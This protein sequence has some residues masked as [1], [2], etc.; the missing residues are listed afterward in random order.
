MEVYLP[1]VTGP[2]GITAQTE[3]S[4]VNETD[5]TF[6][7]L[8]AALSTYAGQVTVSQQ[9]LDRT[10]PGFSFDRMIFDQ[11]NRDYCPKVD[12]KALNTVLG[13]ATSQSWT[14]NAGAFD[15]VAASGAGGFYGQVS[16]AKA[17][18]RT[19]AGTVLN[20]T[21]LFLVPQRWEFIAAWSDSQGRPVVVPDYAGVMN[22]AA[23][24][25]AD[26]D[27]GIEGRT[28][29]RLNGLPVFTDANIPNLGTTSTDQAIVGD[30]GEC[31][32]FEGNP[33]HRVLPQ[34]LAGN[35]QVILQQYSYLA[36]LVRYPAAFV[37]I[38]GT[39]MAAPSYTN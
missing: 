37:S 27:E 15:L 31:W 14:G 10:G 34:T 25:S 36:V 8:S 28:G 12:T 22:A 3:G 16:K 11:L 18:I 4:G 19:T 13:V 5:P 24:G 23:A 32:V 2:A 26:G 21:H 29:Y 17:S 33:V 35:L 30:L 38:N 1:Q 20:P 9:Q 7:Y 6:G 39:G